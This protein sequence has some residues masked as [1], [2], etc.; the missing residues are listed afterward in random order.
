VYKER[1]GKRRK[2]EEERK[3]RKANALKLRLDLPCGLADRLV[4]LV[5]LWMRDVSLNTTETARTKETTHGNTDMS[6]ILVC[7][8]VRNVTHGW[9][10]CR[11]AGEGKG[12]LLTTTASEL[13]TRARRR[14]P[15]REQC[16]A[17]RLLRAPP[18]LSGT[19]LSSRDAETGCRRSIALTLKKSEVTAPV[20][21]GH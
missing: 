14:R 2:R 17:N 5:V 4:D 21:A 16:L 13:M 18:I 3:E 9:K 12:Q 11:D 15:C 6:V 8:G 10:V 7:F 20:P 19:C 1:G